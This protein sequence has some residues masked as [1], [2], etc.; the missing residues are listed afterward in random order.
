MN[1]LRLVSR[2]PKMNRK[3]FKEKLMWSE[4]TKLKLNW[5]LKLKNYKNRFNSTTTTFKPLL[6]ELLKLKD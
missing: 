5:R 6:T 1:E 4:R 3:E 2:V